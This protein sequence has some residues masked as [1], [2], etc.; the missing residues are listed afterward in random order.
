MSSLPIFIR[1]TKV[2]PKFA[3]QP[4]LINTA[5]IADVYPHEASYPC[6]L[7]RTTHD[8]SHVVRQ[9]VDTIQ[10]LIEEAVDRVLFADEEPD[11]EPDEAQRPYPDTSGPIPFEALPELESFCHTCMVEFED[12]Q[13]QRKSPSGPTCVRGHGGALGVE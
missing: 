6:T 5:S 9:T 13:K 8:T 1:L 10:T 7:V 11:E 4:L 2:R 12:T 3:D